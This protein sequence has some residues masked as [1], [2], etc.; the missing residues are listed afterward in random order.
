MVVLIRI[1]YWLQMAEFKQLLVVQYLGRW[2]FID[3]HACPTI[4]VPHM[5]DHYRLA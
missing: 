4:M 5:H 2:R 3:G 1:L